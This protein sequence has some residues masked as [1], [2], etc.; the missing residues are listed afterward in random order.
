M[1]KG[2]FFNINKF[3]TDIERINVSEIFNSIEYLNVSS[4]NMQILLDK[5]Q[6]PTSEYIDDNKLKKL[7]DKPDGYYFIL[8]DDIDCKDYSGVLKIKNKGKI[9]EIIQPTLNFDF[10]NFN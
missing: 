2:R 9:V 1:L 7:S 10:S 3:M 5:V 8:N 6:I 4:E